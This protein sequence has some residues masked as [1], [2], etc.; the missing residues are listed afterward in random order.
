MKHLWILL[1]SFAVTQA[2]P[3]AA[4]SLANPAR[5]SD[6]SFALDAVGD[7]LVTDS[8]RVV[9]DTVYMDS[10]GVATSTPSGADISLKNIPPPLPKLDTYHFSRENEESGIGEFLNLIGGILSIFNDRCDRGV[11]SDRADRGS[12]RNSDRG[13]GLFDNSS[14][15]SR[16]RGRQ[17]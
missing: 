3:P 4:D 11:S 15:P 14:R 5:V 12:D 17:H 8:S 6:S 13:H 7:S 10:D 16:E 2:Q 9:Y 1:L